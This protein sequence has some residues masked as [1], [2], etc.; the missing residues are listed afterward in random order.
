M[1]ACPDSELVRRARR[2]ASRAYAPCSRFRV[3]AAILTESGRIFTGCNVENSSYG[4]TL[5]AERVAIATAVA[6]GHRKFRKMAV[7]GGSRTPAYPCGACLQV[8][9]EFCG[10]D[11]TILLNASGHARRIVRIALN[12]LLPN[13]FRLSA[14]K[15]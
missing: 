10:P 13:A 9:C 14:G 4:L 8:I 15:P 2:A 12:D 1:K 7:A 6:A 3:G 11:F 5:C